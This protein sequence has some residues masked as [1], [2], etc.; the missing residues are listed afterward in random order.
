MGEVRRGLGEMSLWYRLTHSALINECQNHRERWDRF[1]SVV[2]KMYTELL[3]KDTRCPFQKSGDSTII[4]EN[5]FADAV[6][7]ELGNAGMNESKAI[8]VH[9]SPARA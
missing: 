3:T 4:C 6:C 5:A 1:V 2:S 8:R 7:T 9:P